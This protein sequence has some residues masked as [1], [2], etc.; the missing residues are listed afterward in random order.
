MRQAKC[1]AVLAAALG[2]FGSSAAWATNY[3]ESVNGDLSGDRLN[4]TPIT[5]TLGSNLITATSVSGDLEYY[6]LFV[7]GGKRLSAVIAVSNTSASLSFIGVQA[8]TQFTEPPTGTVVA[9]LLGYTHF[10]VANG[11]I[12][13]DILPNMGTGAGAKDFTPP[14]QPGNYT[15][16][17]QETSA[18]PS[19][20]TLDFQVTAIPNAAPIP[21]AALPLFAGGLALMGAFLLR[22]RAAA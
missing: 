14:L 11:T 6:R 15:F 5:L 10:G 19:T 7:P 13:T 16:W 20:Y 12:G 22:R 1:A 9:N 17:S 2:V 3:D 8:G 18:T 21:R 4:P